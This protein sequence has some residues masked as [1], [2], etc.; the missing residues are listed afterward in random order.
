[1]TGLV[2]NCTVDTRRVKQT[3]ENGFRR[4]C[5]FGCRIL[6]LYTVAN[7]VRCNW[8]FESVN[9][10]RIVGWSE[11]LWLQATHV[12][13]LDALPDA[14]SLA[15]LRAKML[16]PGYQLRFARVSKEGVFRDSRLEELNLP[17]KLLTR[18]PDGDEGDFASSCVLLRMESSDNYRRSMYIAGAP[19]FIQ[20]IDKD[21]DEPEWV[22]FFNAWKAQVIN[23][24]AYFAV[25]AG[26][27]GRRPP[28]VLNPNP[29]PKYTPR[30]M[31]LQP[32]RRIIIREYSTRKRGRPFG[33]YRGRSR[34]R[35]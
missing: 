2:L 15:I 11:T 33:L 31:S 22:S 10:V 25:T 13:L 32:I 27:D 19:D 3:G 7:E 26:A 28:K 29:P 12:D 34:N 6:G 16:G 18:A 24:F 30:P 20:K 14:I 1:M 21:I 4:F 8:M 17:G 35:A 5:T 23:K 9:A